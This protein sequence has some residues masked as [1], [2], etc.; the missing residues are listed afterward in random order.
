MSDR[1]WEDVWEW[2][3]SKRESIIA[4][5][6]DLVNIPSV[7]RVPEDLKENKALPFGEGCEKYLI[8][9]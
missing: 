4:D 9:C 6:K 2:V 5:L 3:N 8:A 7:A 1:L